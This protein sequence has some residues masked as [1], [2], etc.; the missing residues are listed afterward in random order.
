MD[1]SGH[2][3]TQSKKFGRQNPI[4][5]RWNSE[6]QLVAWRKA[7]ADVTNRYLEQYRHDANIDHRSHAE[8]GLTEQPTIHEGVVARALEAKGI[9]T[10]RCKLNRQIKA[11]NALLRELKASVKKLMNAVKNTIPAVSKN[12]CA[13]KRK[14]PRIRRRL[15]REHKQAHPKKKRDDWEL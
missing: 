14:I 5:E 3:S 7:W 1:M 15:Q 12:P 8:R 9:I 2:P 13:L 4:S 10:N 11:D 6:G